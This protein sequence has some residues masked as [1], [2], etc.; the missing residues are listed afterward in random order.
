[1]STAL[2][3]EFDAFWRTAHEAAP[4]LSPQRFYEAFAFGDSA[5][6]ADDLADL[7]L[8]GDKR[9]TASLLWT[10][11]AEGRSPPRP[12]DLSIVTRWDRTAVCII[13]TT[14][15]DVV[16]F[17]EVSEAFSQAEGE[18]DRTLQSWLRN[19]AA[20]FARECARIGRTPSPDMP[21]LCER[22]CVVYRPDCTAPA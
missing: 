16:A 20:F 19:H 3:P 12:G 2:P 4:S 18:D 10:F 9:A 17:D 13:E 1:M 14:A 7:V 5:A 6:L 8:R 11:E 15:V 22:F 21:V